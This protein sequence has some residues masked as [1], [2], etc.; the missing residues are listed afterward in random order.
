MY[1]VQRA[2]GTP[3]SRRFADKRGLGALWITLREAPYC[4][5]PFPDV[6]LRGSPDPATCEAYHRDRRHQP[7]L[8]TGPPGG[9][10]GPRWDGCPAQGMI[11]L[12]VSSLGGSRLYGVRR[13]QNGRH[14]IY[15][16]RRFYRPVEPGDLKK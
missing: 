2:Q 14:L 5:S 4:G 11:K 16:K 12:E 1:S 8:V 3:T 9:P 7:R 15:I 6:G 13:E 10:T